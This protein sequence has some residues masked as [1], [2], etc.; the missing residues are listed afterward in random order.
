[1][2]SYEEDAEATCEAE[3]AAA[4]S[5]CPDSLDG[6]QTRASLRLSQK[7]KEEASAII[8]EVF[9]R[10]MHI[11]HVVSARTVV[12]E[13]SGAAEPQEFQGAALTCY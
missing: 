7:R 6:L 3:V 12:E 4:L 9:A 13:M 1:M 5:V 8:S 11:R 2:C 10:V